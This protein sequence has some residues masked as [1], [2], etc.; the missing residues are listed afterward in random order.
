MAFTSLRSGSRLWYVALY[1]FTAFLLLT[2]VLAARFRRGYERA[3]W[4]GFAVFGWGFFLMGLGPWM[5]PFADSD[6]PAGNTLNPNLLTT[7]VILFLLP[8]LRTDSN[9]LADI[10]PIT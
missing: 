7:R 4:F 5:N 6:E 2:A 1:T 10:N 8:Y 9:K 3:F